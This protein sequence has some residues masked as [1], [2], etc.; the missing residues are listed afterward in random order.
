MNADFKVKLDHQ[1]HFAVE[2]DLTWHTKKCIP[3]T[4]FKKVNAWVVTF[5]DCTN[6]KQGETQCNG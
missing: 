5:S 2:G 3:M 6:M 1:S 4:I